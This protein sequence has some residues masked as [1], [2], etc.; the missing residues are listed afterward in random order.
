M[1]AELMPEQ[2][3]PVSPFGGLVQHIGTLFKPAFTSSGAQRPSGL[4]G[5]LGGGLG[6]GGG[7]GNGGGLGG[8]DG[9]GEGGGLGGLGGC[10]GAGGDG[11]GGYASEGAGSTELMRVA[12]NTFTPTLALTSATAT[13][14]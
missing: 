3:P 2:T 5:G 1:H 14:M 11:G 10:G 13:K 7:L 4:G 8:G 9:P 6:D 12:R